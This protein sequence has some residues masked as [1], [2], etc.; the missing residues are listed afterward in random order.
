MS[1]ENKYLSEVKQQ[2]LSWKPTNLLDLQFDDGIKFYLF[3]NVTSYSFFITFV[4]FIIYY[5]DGGRKVLSNVDTHV[6]NCT[7]L[8]FGT[9]NSY[10]V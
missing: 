7:L 9:L 10:M 1:F 8:N 2:K 6:P 3:L 4:A 5:Q